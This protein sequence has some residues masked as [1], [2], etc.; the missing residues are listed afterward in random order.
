M[1]WVP[2]QGV[3]DGAGIPQAEDA[4]KTDLQHQTT[5]VKLLDFLKL[6]LNVTKSNTAHCKD[7]CDVFH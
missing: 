1:W 5:A 2:G 4:G 6:I 7:L 3:N